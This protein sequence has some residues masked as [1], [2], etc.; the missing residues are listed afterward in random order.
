[1][2]NAVERLANRVVFRV[3]QP[4]PRYLFAELAIDSTGTAAVSTAPRP[5]SLGPRSRASR[6][7]PR[8]CSTPSR[9]SSRRREA[10]GLRAGR[11]RRP[12]GLV[13][14]ETRTMDVTLQL[15]PGPWPD[16]GDVTFDGVPDG[17]TQRFLRGRVPIKAR[18]TYDPDAG[19]P[20]AQNRLFETNLFSTI[21]IDHGQGARRPKAACRSP[22]EL[23]RAPP[24]RSGPAR[25]PDR[26]RARAAA[27]FW[28]HRNL[29]RRAASGS[30]PRPRQPAPQHVRRHLPQAR[31]PRAESEPADRRRAQARGHGR[32]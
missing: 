5:A 15:E 22:H 8:P 12:R 31:L 1:M 7:W 24:A 28:E 29:L 11:P 13:D 30:G 17:S 16:F 26:H 2:V 27:L 18:Q 21:V 4:G 14:H 23:S 10:G 9:S 20:K 6:P 25:L 19:R 3:V 32:L